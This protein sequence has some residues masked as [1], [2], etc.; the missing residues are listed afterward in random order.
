MKERLKELMTKLSV[1]SA[2]LADRIGVQRSSISHILNGRN[3]PSSLFIEKL[4]NTFP[5]ID[6]RWLITGNG[7]PFRGEEIIKNDTAAKTEKI[8]SEKI[9][10][11]ETH[12]PE[13]VIVT[14]SGHK[15]EK[16]LFFYPDRSFVEYYPGK[17]P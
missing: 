13:D 14:G 5:E 11:K 6:A 2:E 1:N 8:Q 17:Q 9:R 7:K 4:L 10:Q 16:V 3:L 12:S 15:I